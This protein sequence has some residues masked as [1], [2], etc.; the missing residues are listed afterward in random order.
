MAQS[1]A[2]IAAIAA[3]AVCAAMPA[4]A[5]IFDRTQLLDVHAGSARSDLVRRLRN[6]GY[7]LAGGGAVSF[8]RWYSPRMPDLTMLVFTELSDR[9]GIAWGV[10]S[11]EA[12]QKY[13]ID[14]ALHLG[15]TVRTEPF[16]DATLS[17]SVDAILGGNLREKSCRA[18][19]GTFGMAEVNCRLAATEM[20]PEETLTHLL[21]VKGREESRITLR[22]E[23]RF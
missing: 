2:R 17:L 18:D 3:L 1:G 14:P 9:F 12:G 4:A 7:E 13:R 19:Y 6:G 16:R 10:S 15:F 20:P 8:D 21:D 22:F 11:G 23:C 5:Q